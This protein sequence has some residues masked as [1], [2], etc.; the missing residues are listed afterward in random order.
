MAARVQWMVG[1]GNLL[2]KALGHCVVLVMIS[3]VVFH[4]VVS[5]QAKA[6]AVCAM[7]L[8]PVS[9]VSGHAV[10]ETGGRQAAPNGQ[11]HVDP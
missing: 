4:R 2:V 6:Q 9:F 1:L 8:S 11:V 7:W 3:Q 10:T 5:I